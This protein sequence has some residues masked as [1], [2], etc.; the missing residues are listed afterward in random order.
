MVIQMIKI[1]L[2]KDV[3]IVD[4]DKIKVY[5]N[6]AKKHPKHQIEKI[7][8]LIQ[9]VGFNTP[10]V[11]DSKSVLIAGHGRLQA[12]KELGMKSITAIYKKDLSPE[13]AK[14]YRI[15]DNKSAESSWNEELVIEELKTSLE[16]L[17]MEDVSGL[18]AM[19]E[20]EILNTLE[21][22]DPDG[23][24]Q[25][26]KQEVTCPKCGHRFSKKDSK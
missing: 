19:W 10:V 3:E 25:L 6:N 24:D 22:R 16:E 2:E 14:L 23:V 4:I 8:K 12:A 26:Y 18:T 5:A 9:E 1:K 13:Q 20:Q 17:N 21:V 11:L 7:K 15:G